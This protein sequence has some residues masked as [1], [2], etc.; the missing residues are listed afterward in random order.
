MRIIYNKFLPPKGFLAINLF[1][2]VFARRKDKPLNATIINHEAI[3]TAQGKKLLWLLFYLFYVLEWFIRFIQYR[4]RKDAYRN[5][6]FEREAYVNQYN[7]EYLKSRK[8]FSFINY[9]KRNRL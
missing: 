8:F 4:S 3:H 9:L 2:T 5:I 6:S 7:V 1:G